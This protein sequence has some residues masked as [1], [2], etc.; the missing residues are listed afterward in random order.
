MRNGLTEENGKLIF[1]KSDKPYHAGVI[2]V[3]NDIYYIGKDGYAVQGEHVVHEVMSNGILKRG[4]YTF[5]TYC[6]LIPDSYVAPKK[7][8]KSKNDSTS[9]ARRRSR[10]IKKVAIISFCCFLAVILLSLVLI[11]VLKGVNDTDDKQSDGIDSE[12]ISDHAVI[13]PQFD[14][15][16][17][18]CSGNA[19]SVYDGE[20]NMAD[21]LGSGAPDRPFVF[22][23]GINADGILLLSES[24]ELTAPKEFILSADNTSISIY[25]LKTDRTYYYKATVGSEIFT[26]SFITAKSTRFISIG[27]IY[28]TRDIGGYTNLDGKTVKQ[29][30]IIR[31]TEIDGLVEPKYFLNSDSME[32]VKKEFGFVYELDLRNGDVFSGNY[33]SRFG[34]ETKHRFYNSPSYGQIF[35]AEYKESLRAIF[36]DLASPENYPM[37]LHCTYGL[38]RTGTIVFLLQGLLNMPQE[39]MVDEYQRSGFFNKDY[40]VSNNMDIIIS[41]LDSYE[42]DTICEKIEDYLISYVGIT[43]EDIDS[44]RNILL[45]D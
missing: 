17:L 12:T 41:G 43:Q 3:G 2:K 31:G 8:K 1:Y 10:K 45:E 39:D 44:I 42:G 23:Y 30:M 34:G 13:M 21:A 14:G 33:K 36:T 22:E 19:K 7:V 25:N 32:Y 4:T 20:I 24:P 9:K 5:G 16:I 15:E 40:A 6:K 18:L 28:N 35:N 26:G 38:D 29:G 27:G 11:G 37:Y